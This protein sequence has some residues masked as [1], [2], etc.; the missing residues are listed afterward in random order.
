MLGQADGRRIAELLLERCPARDPRRI[1]VLLSTGILAML[2]PDSEA[3]RAF[4][5]EAR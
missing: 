3:A 4:I 5:N 2:T 1:E